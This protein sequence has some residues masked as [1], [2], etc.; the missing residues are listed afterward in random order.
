MFHGDGPVRMRIAFQ[1]PQLAE[2]LALHS[3]VTVIDPYTVE[4]SGAT[5]LEASR[6][7]YAVFEASRAGRSWGD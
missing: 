2:P 1:I 7:A 4:W 5:F 3:G 6:T